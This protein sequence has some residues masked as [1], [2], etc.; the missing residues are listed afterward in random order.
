MIDKSETTRY[1]QDIPEGLREPL[2]EAFNK[3]VK[4]FR[5]RRWEPAELNG[6]KLCEVVYTIIRGHVD[7]KFPTKPEK[8]R[9][10]FESCRALE[11]E[12]KKFGRSFCVQI[13]RVLMA[14]YE[15][16]NNR[17]V[18]HVGG[19]V[20]PNHM[21]ATLVLNMAKWLLAELI[22][23]FHN[24]ETAEATEA[25]EVIIDR[26]IPLVWRVAGKFRVLN[27]T[28]SMKQKALVVLFVN[29]LPLTESDLLKS[30]EHSNPTVF[31]R[32]VL[33]PLHDEKL[34]E[35]DET[36]K[37]VYLSPLGARFVEDNIPLEI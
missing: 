21:D 35:Y 18:G 33:T 13:P 36:T 19:D 28:L 23:M 34:I 3:I 27:P 20:D 30:V 5:E 12:N 31:R 14:L 32:D 11:S 37:L 22:R 16:R 9:N 25:V 29:Q 1:L 4:N 26:T 24:V 8:P 10:M 7:G 17:G 15:V 2:L 6:G